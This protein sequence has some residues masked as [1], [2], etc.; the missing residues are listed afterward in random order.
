MRL[1]AAIRRRFSSR[2]QAPPFGV[3]SFAQEG[4]DRLLERFLGERPPGF[5]VDVGAFHPQRFST[6]CSLYLK[7]WR[8]INLD[9]TPGTKDLFDRLRPGDINLETAIASESGTRTLCCFDEEAISTLD[10]ARAAFL[11]SVGLPV[12][13]RL[14]VIT[15]PLSDVLSRHVPPGKKIDLLN[16]DVEGLDLDVLRSND[17]KRFR[18][19][20]VLVEVLQTRTL[21]ELEQSAVTAFLRPLG[22]QT[23]AKTFNTAFYHQEG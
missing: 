9:P 23:V 17:W 18:P 12:R 22:Y 20:W 7:G 3:W 16:I 15:I 4:E 10:P 1:L 8:G 6:T 21:S 13:R 14:T 11:E 5:F 19:E 2:P